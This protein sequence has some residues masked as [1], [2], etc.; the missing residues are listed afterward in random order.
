LDSGFDVEGSPIGPPPTKTFGAGAHA[1]NKFSLSEEVTVALKS[2]AI[3]LTVLTYYEDAWRAVSAWTEQT[4]YIHTHTGMPYFLACVFLVC[5]MATQLASVIMVV[6]PSALVAK[7]IVYTSGAVALSVMAQPF[8]YNQLSN[9]D[10]LTLS[11][12]QLGALGLVFCDAHAVA[13][14]APRRGLAFAAYCDEPRAP[15]EAQTATCVPWVQLG[16]RLLLTTDLIYVFGVRCA[17]ALFGGAEGGAVHAILRD[18]LI[19]AAGVLIW[20]GFKTEPIACVVTLASF[21]D[22]LFRFPFW[23]GGR[24]A[25]FLQFHFFQSMTPV[26]GLLLLA[27]LGPGKLS[28]DATT[29]KAE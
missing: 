13:W 10:L 25:E 28:M 18:A 2:L 1:S 29:K 5:I 24:N 27:L 22:S 12:A 21:V 17:S 4:T 19:L 14:P 9:T 6:P 8:L 16:S 20:L 15:A 23:H 11:F 3:S 26:G 7:P